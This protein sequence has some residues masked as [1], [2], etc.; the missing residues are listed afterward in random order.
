MNI[1]TKEDGVGAIHAMSLSH[2]KA[3]GRPRFEMMELP[4]KIV[5]NPKPNI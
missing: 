1:V 5:P 4:A 3:K 2:C